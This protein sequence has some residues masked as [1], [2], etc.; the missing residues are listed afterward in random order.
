MITGNS[1]PS[2]IRDS[3]V[4]RPGDK[5]EESQAQDGPSSIVVFLVD[6]NARQQ[7]SSNHAHDRPQ[8][9]EENSQADG[10]VRDLAASG[11]RGG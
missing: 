10:F 7:K 5:H 3:D 1:L 9:K 8:A 11:R 4:I 2:V 6:I